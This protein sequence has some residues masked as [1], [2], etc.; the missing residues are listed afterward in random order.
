[1]E[2]Q[3][4]EFISEEIDSLIKKYN[5]LFGDL[6]RAFE[7][8]DELEQQIKKVAEFALMLKAELDKLRREIY[9]RK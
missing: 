8:I 7:R 9:A 2:L 1:M 3:K 5:R 4:L 6:L